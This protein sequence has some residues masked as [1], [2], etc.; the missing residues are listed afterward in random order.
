MIICRVATV[1]DTGMLKQ[2]NDAFNGDG[3]NTEAQM[4][5]GLE[6]QDAETVFVAEQDGV[7]LGFCC[8]Q[9]LRSI[10]YPVFYA[11]ITELYVIPSC[12]RQGV[13]RKLVRYAED[14]YRAQEI[15]DFQLFTGGDNT[16]AQRFYERIGYW[17]Q[18]DLLY[19]KR[20]SWE[21]E[22]SQD[23]V[24]PIS[25]AVSG[26]TLH[27]TKL[28]LADFPRAYATYSNEDTMRYAYLSRFESEETFR[29]YFERL[30]AETADP[31]GNRV[32][33][34]V[35][36]TAGDSAPGRFVGIAD[37]ELDRLGADACN[38]EIGYFLLPAMW[39]KGYASRIAGMLLDICF[40]EYDVHKVNGSCSAA[41]GASERVMTKNGMRREGVLRDNRFKNGI[42]Y[43]EYRF[44]ITREEYL[45]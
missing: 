4:R 21:S 33:Y 16:T 40:R 19:R 9:L 24:M 6:R 11:E 36:E 10:C 12:Q 30:V 29:P 26:R 1:A 34:A 17:R 44:G 13:G 38:A 14:W 37:F 42:W 35:S 31:G 5:T 25:P 2:L 7:L 18:E 41:N 23:A 45:A 15:H 28:T 27:M 3:C 22:G 43:D 20:D 32:A 39:G 8:G